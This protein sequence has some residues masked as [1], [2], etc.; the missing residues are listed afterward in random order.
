ML[1]ERGLGSLVDRNAV[2]RAFDPYERVFRQYVEDPLWPAFKFPLTSNEEARL[3]SA[4]KPR[5]IQLTSVLDEI[6]LKIKY[7]GANPQLK[8]R[9]IYEIKRVAQGLLPEAAFLRKPKYPGVSLHYRTQCGFTATIERPLYLEG[10][11]P[12]ERF[13]AMKYFHLG[14]R[15]EEI[16]KRELRF[17]RSD[18]RLAQMRT[19]PDAPEG[20]SPEAGV[21]HEAGGSDNV[22]SSPPND[23]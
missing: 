6:S 4:V 14:H 12:K 17:A 18:G 16:L 11:R 5:L 2:E 13:Q 10:G 15:L 23:E 9:T 19:I 20:A 7:G 8:A 21:T 3:A 22:D 1:I